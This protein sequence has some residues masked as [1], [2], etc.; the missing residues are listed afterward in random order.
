VTG[1]QTCCS[2][3]LEKPEG[4][5]SVAIVTDASATIDLSG[6]AT[7]DGNLWTFNDELV[8]DA[9]PDDAEGR[10]SFKKMP[11]TTTNGEDLTMSFSGVL[12]STVPYDL[13]A[14]LELP[15]GIQAALDA[16]YIKWATDSVDYTG[17]AKTVELDETGNFTVTIAFAWGEKFNNQNPCYYYD[18]EAA[19]EKDDATMNAEM[20]EF[21]KVICDLETVPE[22]FT[23]LEEFKG[24]FK[25][26]LTA[27][28]STSGETVSE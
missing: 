18:S 4:N 16:G 9:H 1:F 23:G 28:P 26:T 21:F 17:T 5:V 25:V 19:S 2:S 14:K 15:A 20:L 3:D 22:D 7:K 6:S 13:T 11:D 8:F 12:T 27:T 10:M 24:K